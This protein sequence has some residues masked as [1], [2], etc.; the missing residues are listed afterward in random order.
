LK[1]AVNQVFNCNRL[2]NGLAPF[3]NFAT[4]VSMI[5]AGTPERR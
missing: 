2:K 1:V 4:A 3:I 5:S